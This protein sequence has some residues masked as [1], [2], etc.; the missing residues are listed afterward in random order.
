MSISSQFIVPLDKEST[1]ALESR[2]GIFNPTLFSGASFS[3]IL[4]CGPSALCKRLESFSV[5]DG[6]VL[7]RGGNIVIEPKHNPRFGQFINGGCFSD[8][9]GELL[10]LLDLTIEAVCNATEYVVFVHKNST[11]WK[12][13]D[14]SDLIR[15]FSFNN[16]GC[17]LHVLTDLDSKTN[18]EEHAII[19]HVDFT[20][21]ESVS[22]ALR[23]II[24]KPSVHYV[25][26]ILC[27]G[28]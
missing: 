6:R 8:I 28:C 27:K 12:K 10:R 24:S 21:D 20:N 18:G 1:E 25:S 19:H 2:Y 15:Q 13:L 22:E 5:K 3:D 26:D 14:L 16:S 11:S 4:K 7:V 9:Q 17:A 23:T